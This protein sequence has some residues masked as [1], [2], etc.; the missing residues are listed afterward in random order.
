MSKILRR[1]MFR[2]GG[3]VSSYGNGITAPLVPGYQM[4]G[5]INTPRRGLVSL[6]GGYS[7]LLENINKDFG[8]ASVGMSG[9]DTN[10]IGANVVANAANKFSNTVAP[11]GVVNLKEEDEENN[12]DIILKSDNLITSKKEDLRTNPDLIVNSKSASDGLDYLGD[13]IT[14]EMLG[15]NTETVDMKDV[16]IDVLVDGKIVQVKKSDTK[17]VP[18]NTDGSIGPVKRVLKESAKTSDVQDANKNMKS[19]PA[20]AAEMGADSEIDEIIN[21]PNNEDNTLATTE[22]SAKD[23]IRENQELFK[24]LLGGKK[25]RGQDISDMLLRFSGSQGN[26]VGEKFQN[27][28][29]AESAAGPG[30]G[31]KINQTAAALAINDYVAGKRSK[32]QGELLTKKIDYELD[33]KNKFLTPQEGDSN[34]EIL[35][36][37]STAYK[38]EPGSNKAIKQLLKFRNPGK[39]I[40][41]ITADPTDK[42]IAKKLEI[43]L[44][45]VTYKGAKT[46]IE[47]ISETDIQ[48]IPFSGI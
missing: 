34:A 2:G 8:S 24:E 13:G 43:G 38:I 23:A 20:D 37:I 7:G 47:K 42:K 28:T 21:N 12:N 46:I 33:A 16:L 39:K 41:G 32:E 19:F 22:V 31:E 26:T 44:N 17:L 35:R 15:I 5:S 27:Y 29:R 25:A 6:P 45:I 11:L 4:G 40:Y 3:Q 18:T 48:V 9:I 10:S 1:P 30:R 14:D 36:K